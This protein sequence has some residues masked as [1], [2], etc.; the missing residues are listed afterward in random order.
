MSSVNFSP[1]C[2][3]IKPPR[4]PNQAEVGR[5]GGTAKNSSFKKKTQFH[6]Q[7]PVMVS[8]TASSSIKLALK[9]F[10][11]HKI[12]KVIYVKV[13]ISSQMSLLSPETTQ[14][15]KRPMQTSQ[16][17]AAQALKHSHAHPSRASHFKNPSFGC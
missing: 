16:T 1:L 12:N 9:H 5:E 15:F 8:L 13:M 7:H 6:L 11:P 2:N 10:L 4:S 3:Q 14:I 17:F